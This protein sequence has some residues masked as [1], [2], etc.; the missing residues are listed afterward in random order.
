MVL[1]AFCPGISE[2]GCHLHHLVPLCVLVLQ[3]RVWAGL[4]KPCELW[5][6]GS[7]AAEEEALQVQAKKGKR[8]RRV[9]RS[10]GFTK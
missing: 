8:K 2:S 4:E 9:M 5:Q 6:G 3:R 1:C 7:R 10:F